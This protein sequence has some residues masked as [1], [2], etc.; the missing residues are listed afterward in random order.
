MSSENV[1]EIRDLHFSYENRKILNDGLYQLRRKMG[2]MFQ[3]SG[4]FSDLTVYE[5]IAF[6]MREHTDLSERMIREIGRASCRERV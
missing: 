6:P 1:V 5:N 2:V 3:V 4:L